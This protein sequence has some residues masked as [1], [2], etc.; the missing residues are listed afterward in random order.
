LSPSRSLSNF[1]SI[2][3]LKAS[4]LVPEPGP[5]QTLNARPQPNPQSEIL[6]HP[7][8]PATPTPPHPQDTRRLFGFTEKC[9]SMNEAG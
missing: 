3:Q 6:P 2:P 5:H 8:D 1:A 4:R 9:Y 7:E